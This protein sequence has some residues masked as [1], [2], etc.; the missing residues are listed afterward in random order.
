VGILALYDSDLTR[1]AGN[2]G[3]RREGTFGSHGVLYQVRTP[4]EEAVSTP[5]IGKLRSCRR[6]SLANLTSSGR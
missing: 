5:K 6:I 2:D 1:D 4:E 3:K